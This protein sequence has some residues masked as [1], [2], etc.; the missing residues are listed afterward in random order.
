MILTPIVSTEK[1][2]M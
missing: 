1:Y 2:T